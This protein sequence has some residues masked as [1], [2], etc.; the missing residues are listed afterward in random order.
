[1]KRLRLLRNRWRDFLQDETA[2]SMVE[3]GLVLSLCA[4][5]VVAVREVIAGPLIQTFLNAAR[6]LDRVLN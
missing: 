5:M 1:M 4:A 3:T 6:A 2:S